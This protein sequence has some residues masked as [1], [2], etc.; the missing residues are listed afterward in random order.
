MNTVGG[1]HSIM[2]GNRDNT[3]KH[4]LQYMLNINKIHISEQATR[5]KKGK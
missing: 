4:S 3:P 2:L 5:K 1:L